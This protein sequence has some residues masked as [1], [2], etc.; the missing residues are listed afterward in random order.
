MRTFM[1][2][3]PVE[4]MRECVEKP[5]ASQALQMQEAFQVVALDGTATPGAAGD[6]LL[7]RN[8]GVLSVCDRTT[9]EFLYG[10][11]DA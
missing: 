6:Y 3:D 5:S 9:F 10:F 2:Y 11:V 4:G 1:T 8:D 7:S